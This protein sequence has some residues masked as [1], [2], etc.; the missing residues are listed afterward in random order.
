MGCP[1]LESYRVTC[2]GRGDHKNQW[3]MSEM[4][5]DKCIITRAWLINENKMLKSR[6]IDQDIDKI[7]SSGLRAMFGIWYCIF[8]TGSQ[9]NAGRMSHSACLL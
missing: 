5:S 3:N 8:C 6:T 1:V 4:L 7:S 2:F 9:W